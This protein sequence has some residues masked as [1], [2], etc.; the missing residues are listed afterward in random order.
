MKEQD[1]PESDNVIPSSRDAEQTEPGVPEPAHDDA[2]SESKL[3]RT[4][5]ICLSD[6]AIPE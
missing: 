2:G 1:L 5:T 4:R 6:C 3:R